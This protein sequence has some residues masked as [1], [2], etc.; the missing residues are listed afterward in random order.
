MIIIH[1]WFLQCHQNWGLHEVEKK[2]TLLVIGHLFWKILWRVDLIV[3]IHLPAAQVLPLQDGYPAGVPA[4]CTKRQ[5]LESSQE[6]H[7]E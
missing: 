5:E 6:H 7:S 1:L 2:K 3:K 4:T